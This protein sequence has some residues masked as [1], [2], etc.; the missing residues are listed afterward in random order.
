[1]RGN[2]A[3]RT[4]EEFY[5]TPSRTEIVEV[6]IHITSS[7]LSRNNGG[8][9]MLT[10]LAQGA[11]EVYD[12]VAVFT[13]EG[14]IS[15]VDFEWLASDPNRNEWRSRT[16]VVRQQPFVFNDTLRYNVTVGNRGASEAEIREVCEIAKVNQFL[17]NMPDGLDTV[18]GNDGVRLSTVTQ[19]DDIHV[20]ED[21]RRIET[22][23]HGEL[24]SRDGTYA[25]L[26]AT[27][28]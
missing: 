20:M 26:Y 14:E 10:N 11:T 17:D 24:I 15:W 3:M 2:G 22:G 5:Y 1:M 23:T 27:Q 13:E 28:T 25:S 21:G 16:S 19:A 12:D 18:L 7:G 9:K 8:F 6:F 4:N